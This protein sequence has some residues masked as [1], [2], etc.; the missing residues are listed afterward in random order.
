MGAFLYVMGAL[1]GVMVGVTL[2]LHIDTTTPVKLWEWLQ[3]VGTVGAFA[4]GILIAGLG[5]FQRRRAA[6][7]AAQVAAEM[8]RP[9]LLKISVE[10]QEVMKRIK[11]EKWNIARPDDREYLRE[12]AVT[13]LAMLPAKD[14]EP[15]LTA[16][17]N[18]GLTKSLPRAISWVHFFDQG[19]SLPWEPE[20][21]AAALTSKTYAALD[22]AD[23][24]VQKAAAAC[25][26][27]RYDALDHFIMGFAETAKRAENPKGG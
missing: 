5:V 24:L 17:N 12:K 22:E 15:L 27:L 10:L 20:N 16:P 26:V 8:L 18:R 7:G 6:I 19:M 3:T 11:T 9:R 1:T 4:T 14:Y 25:D 23:Q 21:D 13:W 2:S